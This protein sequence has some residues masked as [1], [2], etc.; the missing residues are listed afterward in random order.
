MTASG[1][2]RVDIKSRAAQFAERY[3]STTY[4]RG[5]AQTFYNDFFRVFGV[6]RFGNAVFERYVKTL[7][8]KHHGYIDLLWPKVLLAEHKSV[9]HDLQKALEQAEDYLIELSQDERPQYMLA[10]DFQNFVLVDL[11]AK[12]RHE[13]ELAE[14][15]DKIDLFDFIR[16]RKRQGIASQEPV[17]VKAAE[18]MGRVYDALKDN[19][20]PEHDAARL[21]TKLT[22]CFFA[23]DT[24]I[25]S[26]RGILLDYLENTSDDGVDLGPR[27]V[28]LFDILNTP[29]EKRQKNIPAELNQ[30]EHINGDLFGSSHSIPRFDGK[31]RAKILKAAKFNWEPVSPAIFG[32]LFQSV[33]S[34]EERHDSGAHYT[35]EENIMKV[36]SPLFLDDLRTEF[37][38]IK[39]RRDA[40]RKKALDKFRRKLAGLKFLDPACGAGNFLIVSYKQLRRLELDVIREMYPPDPRT[41]RFDAAGIPLV[42]VDQFYGIELNGFSARIAEAAMWM[43]DHLMNNE[44]SAVYGESYVRLPL[45]ERANILN[46]DAL[47]TD[48]DD[49]L[50]ATR[51]SYI[52]GNPPFVGSKKMS[53]PQREQ[54]R[55]IAAL[56]KSGGTLDYVAAWF[57]KATKYAPETR[58]SFVSTNSITQGEQVGQL[59]PIIFKKHQIVFAHRSFKWESDAAG[60]AQV[61]VVIIGLAKQDAVEY[62]RLFDEKGQ[63]EN[64]RHISPYLIGF[65][66]P[67]PFVSESRSLNCLP[68]MSMGSK[69][70]DG[71]YF[72]FTVEQK[73]EFLKLEP[74]AQKFLKPYVGAQ[75]F[76]NGGKR[77]ILALHDAEPSEL[78]AMPEVLKRVECVREYR[79]KSTSEPTIK[80]A[81]TPTMYHLNVI[82]KTPF[83]LVPR[84]STSKRQYVPIGYL[85]SGN[86]PSDGTMIIQDASLGTFAMLISSMHMTWLRHVGGRLGDGFRYSA[87]MVYNTFPLPNTDFDVL[88]L[89]AQEVLNARSNHLNQTLADLYDPRTMPPDLRKAHDMLDKAVDRLYRREPFKDDHERLEFLLG[90]YGAMVQK[91]QK[92]IQEP[93]RKRRKAKRRPR[94]APKTPTKSP[95][96]RK[97]EKKQR[98]AK[99]RP[100]T[101]KNS[102]KLGRRD[103]E[104]DS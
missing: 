79:S 9:G 102:A 91:N 38:R 66:S 18:M 100:R 53:K 8:G 43:M 98:K 71:G 50:P 83:L 51:C 87:G 88:E 32:S 16:G 14:L 19:G 103:D 93:K 69:P 45:K 55:R 40:G 97:R 65:D 15:P 29:K 3:K 37:C 67:V 28:S 75:D 90:R 26:P 46:A 34:P 25:F 74:K 22:F 77:W 17:S 2:A 58:T 89:H 33:M 80:L 24:G 7:G 41:E 101:A 10:C 92:L 72:I 86:V 99:R 82:P 60:K 12:E 54:V 76:I 104:P 62:G 96:G 47:E 39:E 36:V 20:Y 68:K 59:W 6:E 23:D 52:M 48:W 95:S 1:L 35:T 94:T 5:E 70:I 49:V 42:N 84:V 27:L 13:F 78:K 63:E 21:L 73:T 64:P 85:Q 61:H 56:G 44:I 4:E 31:T 30:F 57:I 11:D 81:E